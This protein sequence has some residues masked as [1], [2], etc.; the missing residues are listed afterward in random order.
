VSLAA[1]HRVGVNGRTLNLSVTLP[2][3][4]VSLITVKY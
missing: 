1:P 3:Q 4:A 2:R